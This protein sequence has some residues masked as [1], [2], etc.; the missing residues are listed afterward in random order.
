V[1][2]AGLTTVCLGNLVGNYGRTGGGL[3]LL[4]LGV[5]LA[6]IFPALLGLLL[7]LFPG[8]AG[9]ACGI[10]FGVATAGNA[11]LPS[12]LSP[13]SER[14]ARAPRCAW[15]WASRYPS[16]RWRWCWRFGTNHLSGDDTPP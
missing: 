15:R 7:R 12:L 3:G 4:L 9:T 2:L 1:L 6:P 5:C 11:V 10:V 14:L 16:L 13:A 8:D